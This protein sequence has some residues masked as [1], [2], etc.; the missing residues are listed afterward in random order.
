MEQTVPGPITA[1]QPSRKPQTLRGLRRREAITAY[2]FILPTFIGFLVFTLGPMVFSAGLS[3]FDW[4]VVSP[5]RFVEGKNGVVFGSRRALLID[6]PYHADE[7]QAIAEFVHGKGMQPNRIQLTHGHGDHA[8]GAETFGDASVEIFAHTLTP[9]VC[10]DHLT[11]WAAARQTSPD[12]LL[13]RAVWPTVMTSGETIHDLD[14]KTVR[15]FA[16]PGH[17]PDGV[18]ALV[19]EDAVLFAGDS[20][21]TGILPA[22]E[23]GD[24]CVLE[25]TQRQLAK[26]DVEVLVPG[27]GDVVVGRQAARDWLTWLADY[28]AC[29]REAV[30]EGLRDGDDVEHILARASYARCVG[31]R[32]AQEHNNMRRRHETNVRRILAEEQRQP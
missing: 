25:A 24:S 4:D 17:S 27:H 23:W 6:V 2:L 14:G 20:A 12:E 30:R 15:V 7:A 1:T 19:E 3:L 10:R 9:D 32:F 28:L 18:C 26:M 22:T 13:A 16:A 29:T 21:T 11:R 31:H 5:A 8:L